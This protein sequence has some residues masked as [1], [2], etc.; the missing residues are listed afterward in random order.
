[1]SLSFGFYNILL[2][3]IHRI[4]LPFPLLQL[5]LLLAVESA[6]LALLVR[7]VYN[8]FYDNSLLAATYCLMNLS[9][10]T[11]LITFLIYELWPEYEYLVSKAQEYSFYSFLIMWICSS[12]IS[13]LEKIYLIYK[14]MSYSCKKESANISRPNKVTPFGSSSYSRTLR[15]KGDFTLKVNPA[16]PKK[17]DAPKRLK[18]NI[19]PIFFIN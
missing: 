16:L 7:L 5:Y 4:M 12:F 2:G 15:E 14:I 13:I 6:Y 3:F 10:L 8:R 1:M 19:N 9:R 18:K 17:A 11:L